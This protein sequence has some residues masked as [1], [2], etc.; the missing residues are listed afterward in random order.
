MVNDNYDVIV[1]GA[2]PI[3]GYLAWKLKTHGLTVLLLEEHSEIG[4]PFQCAGMVNPSAMERVGALDT[5]LTRIWGARMYSPSGTEIQIG[6]P[7]TTRTWSVC[8]KLFDE[9]VVKLS[10]IHI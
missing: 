7:E 8:R 6:K 3:G 5:V 1:I 10:L 9:R 4:R 2:G